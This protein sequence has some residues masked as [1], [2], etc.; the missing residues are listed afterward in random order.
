MGQLVSMQNCR[1]CGLQE[2]KGV[3][4]KQRFREMLVTCPK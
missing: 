4:F 3:K 2:Y 1:D